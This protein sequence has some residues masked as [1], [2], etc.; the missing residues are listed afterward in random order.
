MAL[1]GVGQDMFAVWCDSCVIRYAPA[2]ARVE[3]H[4][5]CEPSVYLSSV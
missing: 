5:L 2:I 4:A 3:L 1:L